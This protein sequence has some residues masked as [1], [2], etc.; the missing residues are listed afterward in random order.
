MS[1]YELTWITD[2]IAAGYATMSYADLDEVKAHGIDSI[3]NLCGEFCDL[4]EIQQKSGFD[5]HYLPIPDECAPDMDKMEA[6][7]A[8]VEARIERDKKVLVHCR[9]GV[10]RT[11]TFLMGFLMRQGMSFKAAE[12]K[13]KKT[14]ANPQNY[15]QWK[16]LKKYNKKLSRAES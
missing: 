1:T 16:L 3:V 9:F 11:G 14:R 15:C 12:K 2:R 8:W 5:V 4:H 13:L 10:G 7:M 6:A